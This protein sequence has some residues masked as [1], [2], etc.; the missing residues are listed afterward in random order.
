[1]SDAPASQREWR[2]YIDDMRDFDNDTLRSIIRDDIPELVT[3]LES[4]RQANP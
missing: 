2:F 3:A 4:L 1:M